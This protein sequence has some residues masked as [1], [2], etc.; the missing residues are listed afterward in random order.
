VGTSFNG[1]R[2]TYNSFSIDG[3]NS[4]DPAANT[5]VTAPPLDSSRSSGWKPAVT[6]RV[7]V[8]PPGP[9]LP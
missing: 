9:S 8:M 3:T 7:M 2:S 4:T 6:R 1:A 5:L